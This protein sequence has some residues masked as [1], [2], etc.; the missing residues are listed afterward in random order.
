MVRVKDGPSGIKIEGT[1][2]NILFVDIG[3]AQMKV[4]ILND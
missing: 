2:S 4:T 1:M 3:C